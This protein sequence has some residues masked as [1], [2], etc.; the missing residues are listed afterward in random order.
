[1]AF[2]SSEGDRQFNDNVFSLHFN[3]F[4]FGWQKGRIFLAEMKVNDDVILTG[5]QTTS[6]NDESDLFHEKNFKEFCS[7]QY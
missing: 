2:S 1:M 6:K 4:T 7:H 3:W 5:P